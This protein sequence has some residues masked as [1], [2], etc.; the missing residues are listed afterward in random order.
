MKR[1]FELE[2]IFEKYGITM[3]LDVLRD[4]K[5]TLDHGL[6]KRSRKLRREERLL[7]ATLDLSDAISDLERWVTRSATKARVA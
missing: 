5:R 1:H 4:A 6:F 2:P 3:N 7:S